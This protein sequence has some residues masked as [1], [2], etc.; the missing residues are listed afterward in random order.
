MDLIFKKVRENEF[1]KQLSM[2][3]GSSP[4]VILVAKNTKVQLAMA[5]LAGHLPRVFSVTSENLRDASLMAF[6]PISHLTARFTI[7]EGWR[8]IE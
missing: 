8:A 7:S 4:L 1:Y 5:I 2:G 6:P 3:G